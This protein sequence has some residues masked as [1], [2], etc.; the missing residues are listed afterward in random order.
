MQIADL[1]VEGEGHVLP[2]L[3]RQHVVVPDERPHGGDRPPDEAAQATVAPTEE[4]QATPA[5]N[6]EQLA[7]GHVRVHPAGLGV[8]DEGADHVSRACLRVA[9]VEQI[10]LFGSVGAQEHVER[11]LRGRGRVQVEVP[12]HRRQ[13]ADGG[14]ELAAMAD[15]GEVE[16]EPFGATLPQERSTPTVQALPPVQPPADRAG[17]LLKAGVGRRARP[18]FHRGIGAHVGIVAL[19]EVVPVSRDAG[20]HLV[21][22][23]VEAASLILGAVVHALVGVGAG[24]ELPPLAD[25]TRAVLGTSAVQTASPVLDGVVGADVRVVTS[26][27]VAPAP[28]DAGA[29][30]HAPNVEAAVAL[31]QVIVAALGQR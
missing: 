1:G 30:L 9:G 4:D 21:S 27:P 25:R 23:V 12:L 17:A 28:I 15:V 13:A 29:L 18:S 3:G 16:S 5:V 19:C 24:D 11:A 14:V 20:A 2:G 10:V 31:L 6:A 8:Q 7:V 26:A 22:A